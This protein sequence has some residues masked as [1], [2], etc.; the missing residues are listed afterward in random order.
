MATYTPVIA[1]T[2]LEQFINFLENSWDL[3]ADLSLAQG[4][5]LSDRLDQNWR[6]F[7]LAVLQA[8]SEQE[9]ITGQSAAAAARNS[10]RMSGMQEQ[11]AEMRTGMLRSAEAMIKVAAGAREASASV[12]RTAE[13]VRRGQQTTREAA[14]NASALADAIGQIAASLSGVSDQIEALGAQSQQVTALSQ[15]VKGITRQVNMLSLNASIEA[16]R[17]GQHGR[18]FAVVA[19][20]VGRL[21]ER[22]AKQTTEIEAV[23]GGVTGHLRQ[24]GVQMGASLKRAR[25]LVDGARAAS[26]G[27]SD[28]DRLM[29]EVSAPFPTLT[30]QMET[31]SQTLSDVS[32]GIGEMATQTD[33]MNRQ[34]DLVQ[35]ESAVLLKLTRDAQNRLVRFYKGSFTDQVKLAVEQMAAELGGVLEQG[36][37]SRLVSLEDVLALE[38]TE[39]KGELIRPLSRLFDVSRVPL[40]GFNPPKFQTRFDAAVDLTLRDVLDRYHGALP[41]LFYA[42][43]MDLNGYAPVS[44][45]AGCQ[46]WTGD[47]KQDAA[48]NRVK[49]LATDLAQV[50]AARMGLKAPEHRSLS[51]G[52]YVRDPK[53]VLSREQFLR[54][55][56]T[57]RQADDPADLVM[58]HTFAGLS[59]KVAAFCAVPVYVSGWRYGVAVIGWEPR[60]GER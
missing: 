32:A 51:V 8:L 59:G 3:T 56:N 20:E 41:G 19:T 13:L 17:A 26:L 46:A 48:G 6:R 38:Y 39:I 2:V 33:A 9:E 25:G 31:Y 35:G 28:I 30:G 50:Q 45:S 22:T 40:S 58:V 24:T 15:V 5:P 7:R 43:L 18:G 49:R 52:T 44:H 60:V 4:D 1:E 29:G 54:L 57:L 12:G 27:A 42:S 55:G 21:A 16:A 53:T 47:F 36:I 10:V 34:L 37:A 11:M 23:I 14:E